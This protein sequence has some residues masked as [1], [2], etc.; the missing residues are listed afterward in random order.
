MLRCA[1]LIYRRIAD[2]FGN[3]AADL[4][5]YLGRKLQIC[6]VDRVRDWQMVYFFFRLYTMHIW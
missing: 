5:A 4:C 6:K 3:E 2:F 1:Y